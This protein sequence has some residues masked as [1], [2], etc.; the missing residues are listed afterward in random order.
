MDVCLL[1]PPEMMKSNRS[2]QLLYHQVARASREG[3]A[4]PWDEE[5]DLLAKRLNEHGARFRELGDSRNPAT[6]A[7]RAAISE[8]Y[9]IELLPRL[10]KKARA[11]ARSAGIQS[12]WEDMRQ[13]ACL[14]L[15]SNVTQILSGD[16]DILPYSMV[17]ANHAMTDYLD[18]RFRA[19]S[20]PSGP[21]EGNSLG[22]DDVSIGFYLLRASLIAGKS[23]CTF[24]PKDNKDEH[25][26]VL[27]ELERA[28]EHTYSFSLRELQ[29]TIRLAADLRGGDT[30]LRRSY[31]VCMYWFVY[32]V[33]DDDVAGTELAQMVE[34][35]A[36]GRLNHDK[37]VVTDAAIRMWHNSD[38]PKLKRLIKRNLAAQVTRGEITES[39]R[40]SLEDWLE[41]GQIGEG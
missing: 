36:E 14:K 9:L 23:V 35:T 30:T 13:A 29:K 6:V 26:K 3:A 11:R 31:I 1:S 28:S 37:C 4:M 19:P 7:E 24:H 40:M 8:S 16:H 5:N 38:H 15:H 21:P 22:Q 2:C 39:A 27:L 18:E 25:R 20:G 17:T 33:T 10:E 32:D 12:E 34:A 41:K